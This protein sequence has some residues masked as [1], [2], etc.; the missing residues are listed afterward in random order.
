MFGT[1]RDISDRISAEMSSLQST[2]VGIINA[3]IIG[4]GAAYVSLVDG[5]VGGRGW[6]ELWLKSCRIVYTNES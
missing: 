3:G 1:L 6:I 2:I 4:A 5:V